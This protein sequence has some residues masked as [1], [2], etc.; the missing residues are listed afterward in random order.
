[1]FDIAGKRIF[2]MGGASSHD[3]DAGILEPDDP[4]FRQKRKRLDR[5][6]AL[7]RVN[8]VSWWREELPDDKE[9]ETAR[10]NLEACNWQVDYIVSHCAPSSVSDV[11][12]GG[13]YKHDRLTDFSEELKERCD[14]KHWFFGHY[15]DNQRLMEKFILLYEQIVEI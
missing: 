2:A 11:I 14:F 7:Y 13:F 9:Y 5:Q 8:H 4:E 15:H 10:A 12:S 6:R 1:M 3:I